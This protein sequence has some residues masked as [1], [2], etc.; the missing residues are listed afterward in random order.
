MPLKISNVALP[1]DP[2]ISPVGVFPE[3]K[4]RARTDICVPT[5]IVA[6]FTRG[7]RNPSV[8][9]RMNDKENVIDTDTRT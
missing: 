6:L 7:R 5:F 8:H 1:F 9:Q 4:V 2:A 3:V